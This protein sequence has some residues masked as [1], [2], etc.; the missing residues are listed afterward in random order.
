VKTA[1]VLPLSSQTSKLSGLAP[2][3]GVAHSQG[4]TT[5]GIKGPAELRSLDV[6]MKALQLLN[7][8][9]AGPDFHPLP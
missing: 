2:T 8:P 4:A 7:E 6:Q 9:T 3:E 5:L 1:G